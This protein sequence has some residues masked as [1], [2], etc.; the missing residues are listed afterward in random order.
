MRHLRTVNL[1]PS[2]QPLA[3]GALP[4]GW[5]HDTDDGRMICDLCPRACNLKPGDRGFC[6]V[7]ENRDGEMVLSTYG[8]STGFCI[9]PIEKKPLNHFYPGTS[10]LSFGTAGCNLGCKFCQ[11]HDIS[12]ARK[13]EKLSENATP[14]AIAQAAVEL[15]CRSVAY[16]YNDPIV[17][18]EY[19]IDTAKACR[20]VGVKSVA[21]TA[22]YITPQA[23]APFFE[24]FD[25]ANVDLKAFSEEFYEHV[26]LSHL[27]PVLD[28]LEWLKRET[29]VWLEITNL[30][31]PDANDSPDELRQL[32]DWVLKHVGDEVPIHFSA[33]HPD[34]RM[35]DRPR[36][37]HETQ[38]EAHRIA[39]A[40]GL[41]HVYL[42]NVHDAK[43]QSTWCSA[44]GDLLIERDWYQLGRYELVD[45][46]CKRCQHVLPGHFSGV[47]GDWGRK[48]QPVQISQFAARPSHSPQLHTIESPR[49]DTTAPGANR[50]SEMNSNTN[51]PDSS[52][53]LSAEQKTAVLTAAH[54][55]VTAAVTR[56]TAQ[57]SDPTL[58]GAARHPVNGVYV[59]LKREGRLRGCCGFTG[60]ATTLLAG[61]QHSAQR[62]ALED[63]R[64]PPVS[65]CELPFL[66]SEVWILGGTIPV[67]ATGPAR[68]QEIVI[69]RDGLLIQR[70][71]NRGLLLPG[72][73]T[74]N[75]WDAEKFLRQICVKAKL[76]PT[77]WR[78]P[79]TQLWRFE[80][81]CAD[82][83]FPMHPVPPHAAL[84][85]PAA[86][87]TL[88]EF[89]R[90]NVRLLCAGALPNYYAQQVDDG[91]VNGII[92]TAR[93]TSGLQLNASKISLRPAMPLQSTLFGLC[94]DLV[95]SVQSQQ[96][97][98][99]SLTVDVAILDDPAM[100]G[101]TQAPDLR[102]I[103]GQRCLFTLG[104]GQTWAVQYDN[105]TATEERFAQLHAGLDLRSDQNASLFSMHAAA[106]H[107]LSI[108]NRVRP[109]QGPDIRPPAVA[110]KF[111]PTTAGA[112]ASMV[113]SMLPVQTDSTTKPARWRAAMVP[114]A[115]L[116][117]SGRIAA[118]VMSRLE[119]P[120][121]VIAI[122]P[123][124]TRHGVDWAVAPQQTWA[125]PGIQMPNN[126]E[127]AQRL[128][129][130]V[131]HLELDSAAHHA[132]HAIEVE[133]PF[134]QHYAPNSKLVGIVMGGGSLQACREFAQGLA[135][136]I[137]P[138]QDDVLLLISSDMNH[139]AS[140]AE[141]RRLDEIAIQALETL[142]PIKLFNTVR[143]NEISMCGLLPAVVTLAALHE[144][145]PLTRCERVRYG[146]SADVTGDSNRV[147]GYAGMLFS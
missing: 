41:K 19:A 47:P 7:R 94:E 89:C 95:K 49:R 65:A 113:R 96:L 58:G 114:H 115:G 39:K 145:S 2:T 84:I 82:G 118:E 59:S 12:K 31:I 67:Q 138:M 92:L 107:N 135:T 56:S 54:E 81:Q 4:G 72:V 109:Q 14:E 99:H 121:T 125:A 22:G 36:T 80:G 139:F 18:A 140:D 136:A 52:A 93:D 116:R 117:F 44:C 28:T 137:Q 144:L 10:V 62:T 34:F 15:G 120:G 43:N 8:K 85:T 60:S 66:D 90:E 20:D 13:V 123:K 78:E 55:L 128:A 24:Y 106:S 88:A 79:D 27:Q 119:F 35:L 124:H 38:L 105:T 45:N 77:A 100:H 57:L 103:D 142:D 42:G 101:T 3:D 26:T 68:E 141:T 69:G 74:D 40:S 102:G 64:M 129:N 16:T 23:R 6:F 110:G 63:P 83:K 73:A 131:P 21:V 46:R 146:T 91:M 112:L 50:K 133:L 9:D 29:D 130:T 33:F 86:I 32:C 126:L 30:I 5:W 76:P 134:L 143:E 75:N 98:P 25:A 48:R 11:N 71:E 17:W 70:G 51:P 108:V 53:M 111:Y 122:G 37:S 1:P 104:P 132:E 97:D 87:Q 61:L 127:L 147:V